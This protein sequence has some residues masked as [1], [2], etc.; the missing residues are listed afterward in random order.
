MVG[1]L[2]ETLSPLFWA[3]S[4]VHPGRRGCSGSHHSTYQPPSRLCSRVI[5]RTKPTP[6]VSGGTPRPP[7]DFA[8]SPSSP[9][10]SRAGAWLSWA[11]FPL[12]PFPHHPKFAAPGLNSARYHR[13]TH[14]GCRAASVCKKS[15][16]PSLLIKGCLAGTGPTAPGWLFPQ[17]PLCPPCRVRHLG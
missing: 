17:L 11:P 4:L 1:V 5:P 2:L 8:P 6:G 12:F 10:R 14:R 16:Q 9:C 15:M 3:E 13:T 7:Q